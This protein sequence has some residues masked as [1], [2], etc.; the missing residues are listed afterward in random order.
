[1]KRG[2]FL[3]RLR[4]R[5]VTEAREALERGDTVT[6]DIRMKQYSAITAELSGMTAAELS[7]RIA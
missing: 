3:L 4:D 1:M 2:E 5:M 6:A 7:E